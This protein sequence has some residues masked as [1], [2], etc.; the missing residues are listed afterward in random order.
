[1]GIYTETCGRLPVSTDTDRYIIDWWMC[2]FTLAAINGVCCAE[3]WQY[4]NAVMGAVTA[5]EGAVHWNQ[6]STTRNGDYASIYMYNRSTGSEEY[7]GT[8][9]WV[10]PPCECT[11]W[12]NAECVSEIIRRRVRACTPPGCAS[13]EQ[14]IADPT[15]GSPLPCSSPT[16]HF[17]SGRAL[18]EYYD[19][20]RDGYIDAGE[21]AKATVDHSAGSISDSEFW[22][23]KAAS[24]SSID[25]VCPPSPSVL[26]LVMLLAGLVG[27]IL[28]LR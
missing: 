28:V 2:A 1:M 16:E 13:E 23:V 26:P 20:R 11:A 18:L 7:I 12:Q 4:W 17:R 10:C 25:N 3:F 22:L 6:G 5:S 21:L 27:G 24:V 9:K 8:F 19:F 14:L 15:C